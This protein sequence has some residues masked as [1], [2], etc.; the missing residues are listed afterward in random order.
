MSVYTKMVE[1]KWICYVRQ[2]IRDTVVLLGW[3]KKYGVITQVTQKMGCS[4]PCV[5][6]AL[7]WPIEHRSRAPISRSQQHTEAWL[8]S[9]VLEERKK[10]KYWRVR[11]RSHLLRKY[12]ISLAS[13]TIRNI[14]RRWEVKKHIYVRSWYAP[15]PLYPYD[16]IYPF[17]YIQVD[18]K[19]IEDFEAL[20]ALYFLPRKRWLPLYQWTAIDAKTKTR[21][22]AYSH[23]LSSEFGMKF[24]LMIGIHLRAYGVPCTTTIHIQTDNGSEFCAGSKKKEEEWN[25]TFSSVFWGT[26]QSI[27]AWKKYLQWIVERSHRTDDE[28][29]YRPKLE[30]MEN[31][32]LFFHHA[33]KYHETYNCHRPSFWI[34]MEGL[35]PLEKLTSCSILGAKRLILDFP[36]LLLENV[37]QVLTLQSVNDVRD[38]YQR[39]NKIPHQSR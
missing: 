11:M 8:E 32:E 25:S 1:E 17:E 13:S 3:R 33:S 29:L 39:E 38:H 31:M 21:F 24:I 26:F 22:L 28:E 23:T 20:W 27:P 9:L 2:F 16:D 5:Y 7:D 15:K 18:T 37:A 30:C 10:V 35:S 12:G 36:I 19:H 34:G 14:Y 6:R 4:R